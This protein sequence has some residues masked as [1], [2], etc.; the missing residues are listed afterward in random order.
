MHDIHDDIN[1]LDFKKYNCFYVSKTRI[2]DVGDYKEFSLKQI[3]M[4][5]I[6]MGT[7]KTTE[8]SMTEMIMWTG[9][10]DEIDSDFKKVINRFKRTMHRGAW[11]MTP[12]H[13]KEKYF[14]KNHLYT[15]RARKAYE[16]GVKLYAYGG[17]VFF[18]LPD[19]LN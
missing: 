7:Q 11:G 5:G 13:E 15:D 14:Y 1:I 10:E 8:S 2:E 19:V 18:E 3:N 9:A 4:I 12:G 17:F 6:D 16:Q